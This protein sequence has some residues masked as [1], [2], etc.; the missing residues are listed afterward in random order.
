[1][2]KQSPFSVASVAL[3][4]VVLA[5]ALTLFTGPQA[6][7]QTSQTTQ[8]AAA[9]DTA[10]PTA[11]LRNPMNRNP[12]RRASEPEAPPPPPD[13][14]DSTIRPVAPPGNDGRDA[15][16]PSPNATPAPGAAPTRPPLAKP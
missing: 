9:P 2:L 13:P 5:M 1:M 15:V 7:A 3:P 16:S 14:R 10:V 11:P 12:A 8:P 4:G 6:V